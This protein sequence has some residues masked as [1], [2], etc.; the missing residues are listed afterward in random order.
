M[1]DYLTLYAYIFM[2]IRDKS[3]TKIIHR[4]RLK[5]IIS[6]IIIRKGGLPKILVKDVI[7]DMIK[8]KLIKQQYDKYIILDSEHYKKIKLRCSFI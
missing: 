6:R 2:K 4:D 8:L 7:E 5:E 1:D 3:T